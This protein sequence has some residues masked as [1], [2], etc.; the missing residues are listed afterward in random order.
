[1][2]DV[3][4][5]TFLSFVFITTFTPGPNNVSSA[6]MG[7]LHG[8]R[9]TVR[10]L[11]GISVGFFFLMLACGW[12]SRT[13]LDAFPVLETGLRFLG[14]G[15]ILW[16]SFETLRASY[17]FEG[18]DQALLGFAQG[19]LLQVLNPKAIVYGVTLYSTFLVSIAEQRVYLLL[20]ALLLAAFAFVSTSTWAL[21]GSAI[22]THLRQPRV[23]QAVSV[24]LSLMLVYT[25]LDL[26]GLLTLIW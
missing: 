9:K 8:Y 11:L 23:R 6:S 7:V 10:Y 13:V 16:L 20:S 21:F 19:L 12:T 26:S 25:A 17:A 15:Y 18:E 22:R 14:A 1:M 5:V 2:K 3:N 4:L 24:G